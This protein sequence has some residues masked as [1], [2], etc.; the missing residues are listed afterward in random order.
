MRGRV[1]AH[2]RLTN[3]SVDGGIDPVAYANRLFRDNLMGP[4]TLNRRIASSHVG[5][6]CILVARVKP[7][8]IAHL[9]AG[10]GVERRVIKNDFARFAGL[11]FVRAL[12]VMNDR[13][14]FA[15]VRASLSIAFED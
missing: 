5:D 6:D 7:T 4:H 9:P 2:G 13:Q 8:L 3:V 10:V 14:Y 15:P 11:E 12:S 1:I